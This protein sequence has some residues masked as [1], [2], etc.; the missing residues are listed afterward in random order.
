MATGKPTP[1]IR[2]GLVAFRDVGD[3][4]VTKRFDLSEDLDAVYANLKTLT[5]HGGGDTPEH[6]GKGL[7]EAVKLLSWSENT[8]TA[9]MIFV[10][11]DAPPQDYGDGFN[12]KTWAKAAIKKGIVVNTI[13]CG[14]DAN[15][16][17]EFRALASAA[18]GTFVTIGQEGG[19]VATATPF[20]TEIGKLNTAMAATAVIGGSGSARTAAA[21][22]NAALA[23]MPSSAAAD[24][25]S[26]KHAKGES[27]GVST[28]GAIDVTA[29]PAKLEALKESEM[30]EELR[31]LA[32]AARRDYV[33]KK[34]E[35]KNALQ[36]ELVGLAG[37]RDAWLKENAKTSTDS[38][39]ER[40][41]ESVKSKAGDVGVK[42]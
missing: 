13:R 10:V 12:A 4:Y 21:V 25:M 24:R 1:R 27:T 33:A 41:F 34:A 17:R 7:G 19:M 31:A 20:D 39:D 9:K 2:V 26:F 28:I 22:D 38:F 23:K 14:A 36:K 30:P 35:T 11:G 16:E 40:V 29:A 3:S 15:T 18:D 32:P 42:Y 8:K 6:V 5:A 37:K